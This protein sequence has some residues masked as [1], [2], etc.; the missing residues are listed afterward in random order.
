[1]TIWL[2]ACN[3]PV[4]MAAVNGSAT[5]TAFLGGR[6]LPDSVVAST[7]RS[8]GAD[9][10]Y[11]SNGYVHLQIIPP[12]ITFAFTLITTI[13]TFVASR[14]RTTDTYVSTGTPE[15]AS[16]VDK[17]GVVEKEHV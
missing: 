10:A 16:P 15:I 13:V 2:L 6:Q 12:W 8:L 9:P 17:P 1:M 5:V 4:T 3:I 7:Q 14:K 11:W